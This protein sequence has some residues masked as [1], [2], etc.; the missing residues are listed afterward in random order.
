MIGICLV[1]GVGFV[2]ATGCRA[3]QSAVEPMTD[4][5]ESTIRQTFRDLAIGHQA[6]NRPS[7]PASGWRW[8]DVEEATALAAAEVESA[9]VQGMSYVTDS[10]EPAWRFELV[11]IEDWPGEMIVSLKDDAS[12]TG[13]EVTVTLGLFGDRTARA[14]QLVAAFDEHLR[15]LGRIARFEE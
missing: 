1:C 12:P 5:Q 15:A 7:V 11:T 8:S 6:V 10:G 4:A 13:Y 3:T 9:I 2:S 14:Q